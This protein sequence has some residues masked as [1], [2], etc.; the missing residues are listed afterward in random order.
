MRIIMSGGG[1]G[2]HVYP[3]ISII[4]AVWDRDSSAQVLY[5][6]ESDSLEQKETKASNIDFYRVKAY[7][8]YGKNIFSKML[9]I[10]QLIISSFG[11][12]KKMKKFNPDV[13]MGTGGYSMAPVMLAA[14]LLRKKILLHEQNVTPGMANS[15][16][17]KFATKVFVSYSE[18]VDK[19]NVP[20]SRIEIT[21]NPTR[22]IFCNVD[23]QKEKQALG[24]DDK[25]VILS[26]GGSGG[27]KTINEFIV[28]SK[29]YIASK[30]HVEWLH[31]TGDAYYDKYYDE[32]KDTN[33]L[34]IFKYLDNISSYYG[35]SD[36]IISRSG[37]ITLSEISSIGVATI[38]VPSP[39]VAN[40]HQQENA[41][42]YKNE[43][44]S[45]LVDDD[46]LENHATYKLIDSL[47]D[48]DDS[49]ETMANNSKKLALLG[50]SYIIADRILL[51]E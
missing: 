32:L 48:D 2:G 33:N 41:M 27:S 49:R 17:S 28:H 22:S 39:T 3:A 8:F 9:M 44:A 13:V 14:V 30:E 5:M 43:G 19:F 24:Y 31:V 46:K 11:V 47:I 25:F 15:F 38:L 23:K 50:A 18:S 45:F 29:D 12:I 37:A 4:E 10:V 34:T 36:L 20:R 1:T 51:G 40:N 7:R 21:G 42:L 6:G 35:A 16:F 26:L